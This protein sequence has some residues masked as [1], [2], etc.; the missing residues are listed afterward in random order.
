MRWLDEILCLF[1]FLLR[2]LMLADRRLTPI[3]SAAAKQDIRAARLRT[4]ER[5]QMD[6]NKGEIRD[7]WRRLPEPVPV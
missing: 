6:E 3:E 1:P 4:M 5:S 2:P 7:L